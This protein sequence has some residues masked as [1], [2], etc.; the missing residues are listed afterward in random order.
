MFQDTIAIY[1]VLDLCSFLP[2]LYILQLIAYSVPYSLPC[3]IQ[4]SAC[5]IV[6]SGG[7]NNVLQQIVKEGLS[8]AKKTKASKKPAKLN[9]SRPETNVNG[10]MKD[11]TELIA[12]VITSYFCGLASESF[13]VVLKFVK[14]KRER[15]IK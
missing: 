5:R 11:A 1:Y 13:S 14:L 8:F 4:E 15:I 9:S 3:S 6:K 12:P 2:H 10:K 7:E